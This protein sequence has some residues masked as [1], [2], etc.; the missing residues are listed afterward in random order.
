MATL[1]LGIGAAYLFQGAT[2]A[3]VAIAVATA[4][5]A[6]IDNQYVYP[7]LFSEDVEGPHLENVEVATADEGT[8]ATYALGSSCRM[9]GQIIWQGDPYAINNTTGSGKRGEVHTQTWYVH[10]DLAGPWNLINRVKQIKFDS[11]RVY[12]EDI[13]LDFTFQVGIDVTVRHT[14]RFIRVKPQSVTFPEW[15]R[16]GYSELRDWKVNI[17]NLRDGSGAPIV[18]VPEL[19][20]FSLNTDITLTVG[21]VQGV[22]SAGSRAGWL[23]PSLSGPNRGFNW[24]TSSAVPGSYV[25]QL[26]QTVDPLENT[27][28]EV[29]LFRL[30]DAGWFQRHFNGLYANRPY[31]LNYIRN[32]EEFPW[33][34]PIAHGTTIRLQADANLWVP[35][36][37]LDPTQAELTHVGLDP[38]TVSSFVESIEG[39]GKVPTYPRVAHSVLPNINMS[40][41]GN[42]VPSPSLITT[43][44]PGSSEKTLASTITQ[45]LSDYT[46]LPNDWTVDVST[47]TGDC[48]GIVWKAGTTTV[49]LLTR[50]TL[51]YDLRMREHNGVLF[52]YHGANR[53]QNVLVADDLD[54]RPL[55]D[56]ISDPL[57]TREFD[58]RG[59]PRRL[60]VSFDDVDDDMQTGTAFDQ[61]DSVVGQNQ[62]NR[63]FR[64]DLSLT[65]QEADAVA[66]R[67]LRETRD[68][69]AEVRLSLPWSYLEVQEG[70]ILFGA[71]LG[72]DFVIEVDQFDLG[73][74]LMMEI[75]GY[76][77]SEVPG[78]DPNGVA[79]PRSKP[80]VGYGSARKAFGSVGSPE[81]IDLAPLSGADARTPG[82]YLYSTISPNA[83]GGQW[84]RNRT[85]GDD[86]STFIA[87]LVPGI[88][89]AAEFDVTVS[90]ATLNE[91]SP[92]VQDNKNTV[93]VRLESPQLEL[94]SITADVYAAA[95]ENIAAI[96][97]EIVQFQTATL[98][99][100]G[101]YTLSG[102][103][104]GMWG[105]EI[106]IDRHADG[107][108]LFVLLDNA[109][110][111]F[112]PIDQVEMNTAISF[113][114]QTL[115]VSNDPQKIG[116]TFE[117]NNARPLP[118][119]H[120]DAYWDGTNVV[121]TWGRR[122]RIRHRT[123]T[124]GAV[125]L[126]EGTEVYDVE[127]WNESTLVHT[128]KNLTAG[129]DTFDAD[130]QV[131]AGVDLTADI[132]EILVYQ[133][134]AVTGRGRPA[135]AWIGPHA[136]DDGD[137][138]DFVHSDG[139]LV[140]F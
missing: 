113:A 82:V 109:R 129:T 117:G 103:R 31:A 100:A 52:F 69:T 42:R 96:G 10:I 30:R 71:Y 86:A 80:G 131:A 2:Y 95:D 74:D 114:A 27:R 134:D 8:P 62:V 118:P 72:E 60:T 15:L 46:A 73:D 67:L 68:R 4:A 16:D 93:T 61:F 77:L 47:I 79:N 81:V 41:Y 105:T 123:L 48:R 40:D 56:P 23:G 107:E 140:L 78:P 38:A 108:E 102:L 92:F 90:I 53:D 83:A 70:D 51:A 104:R 18:K 122:T 32:P 22:I 12:D 88:V 94:S 33:P 106:E 58:E 124:A 35:N 110:R 17:E 133:V 130:Q 3:G 112:V 98:V 49:Q 76:I 132:V 66:I 136:Y 34:H 97:R 125:P 57:P 101:V 89:G 120:V 54:C 116:H 9:G 28:L 36:V 25:V 13:S 65:Q 39:T 64:I 44:E 91:A 19:A 43:T 84:L 75:E 85:G 26:S 128:A 7:A 63:H 127:Y 14:T 99:S 24:D 87:D 1:V 126:L 5:G 139:S 50:M 119:V 137:G 6:Y 55:G 20:Q 138:T 37:L 111:H 21:G 135:Y 45:I 59:L 11:K 29:N 121:V 115:P